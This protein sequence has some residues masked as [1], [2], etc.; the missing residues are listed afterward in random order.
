LYEAI[1]SAIADHA[2]A[3]TAKMIV[4]AA[5]FEVTGI[6]KLVEWQK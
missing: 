2:G 4:A 3:E 6:R 5:A 1:K